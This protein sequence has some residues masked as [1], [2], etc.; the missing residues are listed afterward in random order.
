[1]SLSDSGLFSVSTWNDALI[2]WH[3]TLGAER[4]WEWPV[5]NVQQEKV[6]KRQRVGEVQ[7]CSL[8]VLPYS[9]VTAEGQSHPSLCHLQH[10]HDRWNICDWHPISCLFTSSHMQEPTGANAW[11]YT[12][13]Y[14]LHNSIHYLH[15]NSVCLKA[16]TT[17]RTLPVLHTSTHSVHHFCVSDGSPFT[18]T[19]S[20]HTT[21]EACSI[22]LSPHA[23]TDPLWADMYSLSYH[24]STSLVGCHEE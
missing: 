2:R 11:T 21:D 14:R 6:G 5:A 22:S 19:I 12:I 20:P 10:R 18:V 15:S 8:I 4:R 23:D 17:C 1:M 7:K 13:Q 24:N 16:F 3:W 9:P